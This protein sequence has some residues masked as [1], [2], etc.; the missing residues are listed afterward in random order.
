MLDGTIGAQ[1][2]RY[3][4]PLFGI[5]RAGRDLVY[6]WLETSFR[7]AGAEVPVVRHGSGRPRRVL[8]LSPGR[9][10]AAE[11]FLAPRVAKLEGVEKDLRQS[12]E[13]GRRCAALADAGAHLSKW[14]LGRP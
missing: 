1:D 4:S 2:L 14:L 10:D 13:E 7:R 5:R 9:V 6:A 8:A 12:V 3:L 11:A